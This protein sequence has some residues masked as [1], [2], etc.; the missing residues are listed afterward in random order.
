MKKKISPDE[1]VIS[2]K[3]LKSENEII[4]DENCKRIDYLTEHYLEKIDRDSSG[5]NILYRDPIDGR[6]WLKTYPSSEMQGGGP[7]HLKEISQIEAQKQ[8]QINNN[9]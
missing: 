8:F 2:G 3:W 5:W 6:L 7:P 4:K 1:K 9:Q